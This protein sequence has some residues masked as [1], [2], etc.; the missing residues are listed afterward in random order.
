[1]RFY[2]E[3][4]N[5]GSIEITGSDLHHMTNVMRVGSGDNVELFDGK[6]TIAQAKIVSID[7]K[8][9]TLRILQTQKQPPRQTSRITI[10]AS[11]AKNDRFEW[12]VAKCTELGVDAIVP[13]IF[14]RTVKQPKGKNTVERY[15]KIA[16]ASAGQCQRPHLP[17]IE[18]SENFPDSLLKIHEQAPNTKIIFGSLTAGTE[19]IASLQFGDNNI[20]AFIGP[21]GG[22]TNEEEHLLIENQATP[23]RLTETILRIE[24]AAIAIASFLTIKRDAKNE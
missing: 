24:T 21:E 16:L 7:K 15:R 10:F 14:T 17:Q 8:I 1:M 22:F 18:N 6:G 20:A 3:F 12:L 2:C 23:I 5:D 4:I 19:P 11:V 9:A 13:T